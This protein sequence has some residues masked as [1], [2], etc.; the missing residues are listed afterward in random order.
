MN[1]QRRLIVLGMDLLLLAELTLC[2]YWSAPHGNAMAA[3]FLKTYLPL[4]AATAATA[5][6]L[7]RRAHRIKAASEVES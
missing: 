3:V 6:W 1:T 4:A 5:W 7:L 2:M